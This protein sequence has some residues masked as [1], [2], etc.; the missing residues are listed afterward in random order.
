[1]TIELTTQ[2]REDLLIEFATSAMAALAPTF[3]EY[4][5][6]KRRVIAHK[7]FLLADAMLEAYEARAWEQGR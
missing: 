7:A 5:E 4:V 3:G 6:A 2:D 1:M